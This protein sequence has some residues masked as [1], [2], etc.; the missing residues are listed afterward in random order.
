MDACDEER[1]GDRE[2][3]PFVLAAAPLGEFLWR[4]TAFDEDGDAF[5]TDHV[6]AL[7]RSRLEPAEIP[8]V[9]EL[10]HAPF[11]GF[12][13]PVRER[14][15]VVE[16]RDA[17]LIDVVHDLFIPVGELEAGAWHGGAFRW[18]GVS[19]FYHRERS[20]RRELYLTCAV[21]LVFN[22]RGCLFLFA[23]GYAKSTARICKRIVCGDG[24]C[25]RPRCRF[26]ALA[27]A[28]RQKQSDPLSTAVGAGA[29]S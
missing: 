25:T 20:L 6:E 10:R 13:R 5:G 1:V 22:T 23:S 12:V 29:A 14:G 3:F 16:R 26:P 2:I 18:W 9:A 8:F 21:P 7:M 27:P 15:Q 11:K 17:E 24:N 4:I 28:R 19:G